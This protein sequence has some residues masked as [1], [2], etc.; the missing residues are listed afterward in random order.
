[1]INLAIVWQYRDRKV[2]TSFCR[3]LLPANTSRAMR[4]EVHKRIEIVSSI[5]YHVLE[6]CKRLANSLRFTRCFRKAGHKNSIVYF[7]N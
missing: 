4:P 1:M 5:V 6:I 7:E 3:N 2:L